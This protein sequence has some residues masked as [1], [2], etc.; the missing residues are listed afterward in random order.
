M[1]PSVFLNHNLYFK[2]K[3]F[4]V[5][6]INYNINSILPFNINTTCCILLPFECDLVFL[7]DGSFNLQFSISDVTVLRVVG[8]FIP[9]TGL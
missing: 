8:D 3:K 6:K 5:L 4:S 7:K 9:P 1:L 2:G